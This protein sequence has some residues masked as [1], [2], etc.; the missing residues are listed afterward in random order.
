VGD[1]EVDCGHRRAVANRAPQSRQNGM[2]E[3][4]RSLRLLFPM[5]RIMGRREGWALPTDPNGTPRGSSTE[6]TQPT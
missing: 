1:P 5:K 6:T 3:R 4:L 2:S